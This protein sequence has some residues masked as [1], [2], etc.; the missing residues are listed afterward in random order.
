ML[1]HLFP[2]FVFFF[3]PALL[4]SQDGVSYT[5]EYD[6]AGNMVA[7]HRWRDGVES[8]TG[9]PPDSSGRNRPAMIG[10]V[11]LLWDRNGNLA[12]KGTL[13]LKYDFRNLLT[14]VEDEAGTELVRYVYDAFKRR[15]RQV[16]A[17]M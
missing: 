16:A 3:I 2:L 14:V 10:N 13:R 9:M 15:V 6:N 5:F 1:R 11:P 4:L 12:G 7:K 17:A 8:V